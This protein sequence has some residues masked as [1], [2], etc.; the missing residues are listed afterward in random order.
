MARGKVS[1]KQWVAALDKL[2][3]GG[4]K[5]EGKRPPVTIKKKPR[6]GKMTITQKRDFNDAIRQGHPWLVVDPDLDRR[7]VAYV[8]KILDAAAAYDS[9]D[10]TNAADDHSKGVFTLGRTRIAFE[11]TTMEVFGYSPAEG[12]AGYED[13]GLLKFEKIGVVMADGRRVGAAG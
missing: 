1:A 11:V 3:D 5:P 7:G 13:I 8:G 2:A 9:F 4:G 10:D 6:K 12:R